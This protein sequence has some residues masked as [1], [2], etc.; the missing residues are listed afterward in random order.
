MNPKASTTF[1][2]LVMY[3]LALSSTTRANARD[4]DPKAS[5]L[6]H[7][8]EKA[9]GYTL[10]S[11]SFKVQELAITNGSDPETRNKIGNFSTWQGPDGKI[12][13]SIGRKKT[14]E[15]A[16]FWKERILAGSNTFNDDPDELN[17]AFYGDMKFSLRGGVFDVSTDFTITGAAIAQGSK[18]TS[19]NWWFGCKG[20]KNLNDHKVNCPANSETGQALSLIFRRGGWT[21]SGSSVNEISLTEIEGPQKY[22]TFAML[23]ERRGEDKGTTWQD[24]RFSPPYVIYYTRE[25]AEPLKIKVG[26]EGLLYDS[27]GNLFDTTEDYDGEPSKT[28]AIF[29]LDTDGTSLYASRQSKKYLFHHSTFLAGKDVT[30]AGEMFVR[31]G[32]IEWMSNASGHYRPS[33]VA[34]VQLKQYLWNKGYR[35]EFVFNAVATD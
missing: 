1:F 14:R 33:E 34:Y 4:L 16:Q 5:L 29:V 12:T 9:T 8:V 21:Q 24:P 26:D 15:V 6:N 30:S 28:A 11:G 7:G 23:P 31:D 19:N 27:N 2:S 13:W 3:V 22:T 18:F 35:R 10:D 17:F 20:G 32:V 25:Q